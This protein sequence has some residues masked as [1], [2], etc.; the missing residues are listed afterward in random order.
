MLDVSIHSKGCTECKAHE[1][2]DCSTEEYRLWW[3][4]HEELQRIVA[5]DPFHNVMKFGKLFV[6]FVFILIILYFCYFNVFSFINTLDA[7][8]HLSGVRTYSPHT[9]LKWRAYV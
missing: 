5:H 1:G 6:C 8:R 7:T 9:P 3:E 4:V 2:W